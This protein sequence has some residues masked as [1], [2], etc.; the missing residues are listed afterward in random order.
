MLRRNTKITCTTINA[1][2][3]FE[4]CY[5]CCTKF[6]TEICDRFKQSPTDKHEHV[7]DDPQD[8]PVRENMPFHFTPIK[9]NM[10]V[11]QG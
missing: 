3:T 4:F 5:Y 8:P 11:N 10:R 7:K 9:R 2:V 6:K 1:R